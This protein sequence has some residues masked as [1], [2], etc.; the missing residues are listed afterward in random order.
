VLVLGNLVGT[1]VGRKLLAIGCGFLV[2]LTTGSRI[3]DY[4]A[5][6]PTVGALTGPRPRS[7]RSRARSSGPRR[8]S[9]RRSSTG[10]PAR[11]P[12]RARW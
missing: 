5:E 8:P 7:A 9:T 6:Y 11:Q 1:A 12:A 3:N 4:F 2:L 10:G